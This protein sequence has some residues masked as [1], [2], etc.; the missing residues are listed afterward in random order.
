MHRLLYICLK[1]SDPYVY[2]F[3]II[4]PTSSITSSRYFLR[5]LPHVSL[6]VTFT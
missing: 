3:N 5:L 4:S 1:R 6:N 2:S